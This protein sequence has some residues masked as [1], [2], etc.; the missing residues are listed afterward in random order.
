MFSLSNTGLCRTINLL[1]NC[2]RRTNFIRRK[3]C[4]RDAAF[5]WEVLKKAP[6]ATLSLTDGQGRPYAVPVN[7]AVD[8]EYH[9]VYFHCAGAGEKW[10]LL[11]DGAEVCL[12]AVSRATAVPNAFTMAYASAVLRGRAEVVTD[13]GEWTRAL[14]QM[15]YALD[16]KGMARFTESVEK[17]G[18]ATKVIRITPRELTGKENTAAEAPHHHHD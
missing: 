14:L 18:P 8:E 11:K 4:E 7:Q 5:A 2:F 6:Y 13:Q 15:C 12:S 17:Y 10:E 16:P 3:E 1:S 9:V